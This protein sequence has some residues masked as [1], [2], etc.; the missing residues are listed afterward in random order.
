MSYPSVI[1]ADNPFAYWRLGE[2]EGTVA[3][4]AATGNHNLTY[5]NVTLGQPGLIAGD[6]NKSVL[7]AGTLDSYAIRN[8]LSDFAPSAFTISFIALPSFSMN[9]AQRS[10]LS[11]Y[12]ATDSVGVWHTANRGLSLEVGNQF[13]ST[14]FGFIPLGASPIH[15]AVTWRAYDGLSSLFVNGKLVGTRTAFTQGVINSAGALV[16]GQEQSTQGT[17]ESSYPYAGYM[18]DLA[19]YTTA[20]SEE[21]IVA[22]A[23]EAFQD[24]T[25]PV[26][27]GAQAKGLNKVRV[28][29]SKPVTNANENAK[30]NISGGSIQ[31]VT[32]DADR[33]YADLEI[34]GVSAGTTY[35]ITLADD[36]TSGADSL[37]SKSVDFIAG[38]SAGT[39]PSDSII[40]SEVGKI[41]SAYAG[42]VDVAGGTEPLPIKKYLMRAYKTDTKGYVFWEATGA[43]DLSGAAS[44]YAGD[45]L[46]DI[47]V[48]SSK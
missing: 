38:V 10:F 22:Q 17:I 43:P 2:T 11:Y 39:G 47:V 27:L 36:V 4:D 16:V 45:T 35:T 24:G 9:G 42:D 44:G 46:T 1:L 14:G 48:Y 32:V 6:D 34:A 7:F 8:P 25:K 40:D 20:L 29:F 37:V 26:A 19:M 28:F 23:Q 13:N 12:K 41:E 21:R 15:V 31:N 5:N 18:Q 30:F 3:V 33:M